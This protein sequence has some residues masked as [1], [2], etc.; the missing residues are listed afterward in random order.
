MDSWAEVVEAKPDKATT[1]VKAQAFRKLLQ[2]VSGDSVF[3]MNL[4]EVFSE[5]SC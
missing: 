1:K 5:R 2:S 4:N 3:V